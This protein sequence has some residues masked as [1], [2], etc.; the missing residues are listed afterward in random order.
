MG[1]KLTTEKA[2]PGL[3]LQAEI[4]TVMDSPQNLDQSATQRRHFPL[5][6]VRDYM[7]NITEVRSLP[8]SLLAT[9]GTRF[10]RG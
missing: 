10:A 3:G 5:E 4:T 1:S 6:F 8:A 9:A 2:Q 7:E